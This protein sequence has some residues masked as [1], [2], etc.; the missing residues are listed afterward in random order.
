MYDIIGDIHGFLEPLERLLT[1]LGYQEKGGVWRHPERKALFLG[2]FVDRGPDQPEVVALVRA[3][4][5][6]GEALAIMGNHEFNAV[7]FA[8]PH[9]D[10]PGEYLRPHTDKNRRQHQAFLDQVGEGSALHQD[11]VGWFRTLPLYLD[12]PEFRAVHAC[13][14]PEALQAVL[15]MLDEEGRLTPQGWLPAAEKGDPVFEGVETLLKGLEISLPEGVGFHDKDGNPRSNIRTQ[16]WMQGDFTYRDLAIV[17]PDVIE[18]IPHTPIP[19]DILPG[20]DDDKPVFVGHYW[21]TGEPEPL[22]DNVACLD[23][24]VVNRTHGKLVAYRWDGQP[25]SKAGYCWVESAG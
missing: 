12:L 25:L 13:W 8:T 17:P 16:W 2:D 23:Y 1:K 24:S 10:K 20:Y 11:I 9:P 4:V 15:P 6:Q 7:A 14:H 3:M 21:L 19:G 5:E 18:R 22:A